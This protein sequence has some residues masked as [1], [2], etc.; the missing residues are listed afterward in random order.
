MCDA[1]DLAAAGERDA[2]ALTGGDRMH[3]RDRARRDQ[4]A[5]PQRPTAA[6]IARE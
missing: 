6:R 1:P 2:R 4:I 3:A 5:G